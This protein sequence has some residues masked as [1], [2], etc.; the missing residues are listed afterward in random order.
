MKIKKVTIIPEPDK[1]IPTKEDDD[2]DFTRLKPL[3]RSPKKVDPKTDPP[4]PLEIPK[5][6]P[7]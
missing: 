2:N 3:I 6:Q 7:V 4:N 1:R 5:P